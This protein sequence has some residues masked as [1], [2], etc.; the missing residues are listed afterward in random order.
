MIDQ[1]ID[2]LRLPASAMVEQRI[3]K[4]VLVEHGTVTAADKRAIDAGFDRIDWVAALKPGSIGVPAY[5]DDVRVV[6]EIAV[7]TARLRGDAKPARLAALLHRVIP[8]PVLLVLES[9]E[10]GLL[11]LAPKRRS[12][13][14]AAKWVVEAGVTAPPLKTQDDPQQL[15]F[16]ASLAVA[17]LP[18]AS[19]WLHYTGLIERVEAYAAARTTGQFRLAVDG[20]EAA[21][22]REA[23]AAYAGGVAEVARLRNAARRERRVAEAIALARAVAAAEAKLAETLAALH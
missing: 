10:Q 21:S 22:R 14:D 20:A 9:G 15:A 12:L 5:A 11:S 16:L 8:Y 1:V 17:S 23:L 19:L 2:A 3:H 18:R 7:I 13:G 6:E 4:T